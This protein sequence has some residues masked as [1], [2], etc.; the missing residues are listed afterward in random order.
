MYVCCCFSSTSWHPYASERLVSGDADSN[1]SCPSVH[2][3]PKTLPFYIDLYRFIFTEVG[4]AIR[5]LVTAF[6]PFCVL[7]TTSSSLWL[8]G[9]APA[10][11]ASR[12]SYLIGSWTFVSQSRRF[13]SRDWGMCSLRPH[14]NYVAEVKRYSVGLVSSC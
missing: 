11:S 13:F 2:G 6:M 8:L 4:D 7:G 5:A 10:V 14:Y 12:C 9:G 3:D 1:S